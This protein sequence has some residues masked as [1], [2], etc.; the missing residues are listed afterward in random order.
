MTCS[1][2]FEDKKGSFDKNDLSTMFPYNGLTFQEN[3]LDKLVHLT[4]T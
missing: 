2:F 3:S 1:D 4:N